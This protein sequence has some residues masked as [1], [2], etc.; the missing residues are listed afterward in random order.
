[1]ERFFKG[2]T[3]Q[4]IERTKNEQACELAKS[5]ARKV[6][7]P[8]DVFIQ[9]IEDP[10]ITTVEQEPRMVNIIQGED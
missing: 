8:P 9:V 3:V 5:A 6:V 7:I 2:F 10:S 1:M 4:Q